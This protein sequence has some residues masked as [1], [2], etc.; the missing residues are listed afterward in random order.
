MSDQVSGEDDEFT[1]MPPI[2]PPLE[3]CGKSDDA[4]SKQHLDTAHTPETNERVSPLSILEL[5]R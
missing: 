4:L 1:E 2:Q 5:S 3:R